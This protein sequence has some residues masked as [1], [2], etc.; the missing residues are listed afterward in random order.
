LSSRGLTAASRAASRRVMPVHAAADATGAPPAAPA[1]LSLSALCEDGL[2]AAGPYASA[3]LQ[4][5][6][7]A[8]ADVAARVAA[9]T[10]ELEAA[11]AEAL[12]ARL[13]A[14]ADLESALRVGVGP[15]GPTGAMRLAGLP[16]FYRAA[17]G[18]PA[19]A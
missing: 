19:W 2:T 9:L 6:V 13:G 4:V 7:A 5:I 14:P 10:A 12:R 17:A 15:G 16:S 8:Y 3:R 1:G 11:R 18:P